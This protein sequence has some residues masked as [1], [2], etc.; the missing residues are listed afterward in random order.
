MKTLLILITGLVTLIAATTFAQ[1]DTCDVLAGGREL[2]S[3]RKT[4]QVGD[5]YYNLAIT[6]PDLTS[7]PGT[8][9][10]TAPVGVIDPVLSMASMGTNTFSL[11]QD[12][13]A[14]LVVSKWVGSS[15]VE[16]ARVYYSTILVSKVMVSVLI[17]PIEN[18]Y[19]N[20]S[21]AEAEGA[22]ASLPAQITSFYEVNFR[23]F[24]ASGPAN[25]A[26]H[27][28]DPTDPTLDLNLQSD[29]DQFQMT[30]TDD[31]DPTPAPS[32]LKA[33]N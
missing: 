19:Y 7:P 29:E 23:F 20:F 31:T 21:D 25:F 9:V 15:L 22:F 17:I 3:S 8:C 28:P 2:L 12:S 27:Q 30:T 26:F 18:V 24:L 4:V 5:T 16:I 33:L 11:P 6:I 32:N 10:A 14:E 1:A 13:R